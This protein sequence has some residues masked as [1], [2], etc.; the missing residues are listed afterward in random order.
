M[1]RQNMVRTDRL[2][3]IDT[4]LADPHLGVHY[5]A[6]AAGHFISAPRAAGADLGPQNHASKESI[7]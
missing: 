3:S 7:A 6:L 1:Y 4:S 5:P 2:L